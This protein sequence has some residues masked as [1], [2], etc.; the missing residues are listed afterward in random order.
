MRP[1]YLLALPLLFLA[2]DEKPAFLESQLHGDWKAIS[3]EDITNNKVYD[4]EVTFSFAADGRYVATQ[5]GG[6]EVGKYWIE[7]DNLH[8]IEDGMAEKKVKIETLNP[9]TLIFGMN[10]VGALE[11]IVLVRKP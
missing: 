8:T 10:R 11:R 5:G 6:E 7:A 3:W 1:I 4:A 2:C 9:D